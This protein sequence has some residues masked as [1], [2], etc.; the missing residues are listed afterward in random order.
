MLHVTNG[1]SV[2]HTFRQSKIEGTFVSWIDVL[3]DGP[4]PAGIPDDELSRVRAR[5]FE[6]LGWT[7][8]AEG[9]YG[10]QTRN[11]QMLNYPHHE[12]IVLW[13]EH[14]LF[15]QLQLIQILEWLSRQDL[16]KTKVSLININAFPG[17]SPFHGL[18]QLNADQLESLFP[19]R[20]PVTYEQYELAKEAWSAFRSPTPAQLIS[21]VDSNPDELPFLQAA[22][23]RWLEEFPAVNNGLPRSCRHLLEAAAEGLKNRRELYF[24]AMSKE[25]AIF[26]ADA[27]AFWRINSLAASTPNAALKREGDF[28]S[29]T[30]YGRALLDNESDWLRD[31]DNFEFW[32]GGIRFVKGG[33]VW[34]WDAQRKQLVTGI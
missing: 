7:S 21:L 27:S 17:I 11:L 29:I 2:V 22:L 34:R 15:D 20:V 5:Y 6:S 3:H 18:G 12:E 24:L 14:D 1:E 19:K 13:F 32:M 28:Y 23:Q 31:R 8:Y 10:L 26:M 16:G 30:D 4:V 33:I 9:L 25:T